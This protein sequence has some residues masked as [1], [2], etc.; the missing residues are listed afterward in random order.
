MIMKTA[1][2]FEKDY[3]DL[4]VKAKEVCRARVRSGS[5]GNKKIQFTACETWFSDKCNEINLW[6]YWLVENYI[7]TD[8]RSFL[9][10]YKTDEPAFTELVNKTLIKTIVKVVH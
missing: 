2:V 4:V 8:G 10:I 5:Y 7:H 3:K 6:T 1:K 9:E